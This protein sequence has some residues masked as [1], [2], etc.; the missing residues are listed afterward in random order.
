VPFCTASDGGGSTRIPASFTGLVGFKAS[1]G[2]I[3]H[4]HAAPSQTTCVGALTTTVADAARHLDVTA[5]PDDRDRASLPP[6]GVVFERA[7]EELDVAGLRAAWSPNLG[8]AVV[9]PE[10]TELTE[11]AALAL[12]QAAGLELVDRPITLTDPVRTWL[13]SGAADL[14]M[15]IEQGMYPE[16]ADDMDPLSRAVFDATVDLA[17]PRY[18]HIVQRRAQLEEEIAAVFDDVDVLLTPATAVPAFGA[19]GPMP[20]Q[21]AGQKVHPAMV[22]PFTM[23]GNL[24]WNPAVSVPAGPTEAG[25]PIGVQVMGRRHADATVLRLA[26]IYEQT[27]PW[28]R[29]APRPFARSS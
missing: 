15:S 7:V 9:E 24:C 13:S 5:G 19:A 1:Y 6:S 25:L 10:V 3:P 21:I 16:Q 20:S 23:V 11:S 28:P 2:R 12:A 14:W 22:V 27:R 26:R 29:V 4:P 18:A 17:M 8:F